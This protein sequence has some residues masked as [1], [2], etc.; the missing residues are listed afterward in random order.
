MF[1]TLFTVANLKHV[2]HPE[3]SFIQAQSNV[4]W[5]EQRIWQIKMRLVSS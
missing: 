5:M 3:R 1:L 4:A 2:R